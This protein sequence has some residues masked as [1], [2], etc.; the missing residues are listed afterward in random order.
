[1]Q[2]LLKSKCYDIF[3]GNKYICAIGGSIYIYR[4]DD[5]SFVCSFSDLKYST[6]AVFANDKTLV[7]KSTMGIFKVYDLEE[8]VC[9]RT[10]R[11]KGIKK[12]A[13]DNDFVILNDSKVI[14]DILK[15]VGVKSEEI[16]LQMFSIDIETGEFGKMPFT[17]ALMHT[18]DLQFD[19][20]MNSVFFLYNYREDKENCK[21]KYYTFIKRIRLDINR[22]EDV[23][24]KEQS[25]K[26]FPLF[27][28]NGRYLLDNDMTIT[29]IT[30]GQNAGRLDYCYS[31]YVDGYLVKIRLSHDKK[32]LLI[33]RSEKIVVI[34]MNNLKIAN[35]YENKYSSCA[36]IYN[37][38]ILLGTWEKLVIREFTDKSVI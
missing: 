31:D 35:E 10:L 8:K 30:T 22:I 23:Y 6:H 33:V 21:D 32:Y 37:G 11:Q 17:S 7:V 15:T 34:N 18:R 20:T 9:V 28:Y 26:Y 1:M 12:E 36:E 4:R 25:E 2:Y 27:F 16:N 3:L 5:F 13:Q 19:P 14:V 38:R 29:D 24:V